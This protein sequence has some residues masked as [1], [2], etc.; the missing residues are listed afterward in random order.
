MTN[1]NFCCIKCKD[2]VRAVAGLLYGWGSI[3]SGP[4]PDTDFPVMCER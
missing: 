3:R 4:L 1:I 2:V